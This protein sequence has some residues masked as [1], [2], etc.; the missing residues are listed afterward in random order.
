M[1][2]VDDA[3]VEAALE[4]LGAAGAPAG[5]G[6]GDAVAEVSLCGLTDPLAHPRRVRALAEGA[7]TR[8]WR[9]RVDTDA[10][11]RAPE[12]P[13]VLAGVVDEIVVRF[14][15]V[16]PE[17]HDRVAW[18]PG[19]VEGFDALCETARAAV[20]AGIETVCEFIAA[21]RFQAEPC[22]ELARK[23]GARY[24]IRMYRS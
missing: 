19:G 21:P 22:R 16:T 1:E 3:R 4:R 6:A 8:G 5:D 14:Y 18:P 24:D 20:R 10:T 12:A 11:A 23:L 15:G 17:Q 13:E 9:V 7:R 2:A